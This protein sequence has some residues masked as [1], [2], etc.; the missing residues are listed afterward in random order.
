MI[1][2]V[3]VGAVVGS[4]LGNLISF[5]VIGYLARR[6]EAKQRAELQN[7]QQQYMEFMQKE[8]ERMKKYAEMEG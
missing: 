2:S 3:I 7:L 6:A 5:G 1:V 4:L 8:S